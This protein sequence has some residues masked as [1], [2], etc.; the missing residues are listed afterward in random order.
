MGYGGVIVHTSNGG[1][2]WP[3]Q[4]SGTRD[5]LFGVSFVKAP[6]AADAFQVRYGNLAIGD[7]Y[8][9]ITN[10]G[11]VGGL[12]LDGNIVERPLTGVRGSN[13]QQPAE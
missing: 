1:A 8:I 4:T 3:A 6:V 2:T 13:E 7:S 10:T 12:D 9:N 5:D 11:V